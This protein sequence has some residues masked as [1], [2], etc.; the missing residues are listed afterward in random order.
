M[1]EVCIHGE[2][3]VLLGLLDVGLLVLTDALLK[4]VRLTCQG[5][6]V[7]PLEW[8]FHVVVL[9]HPEG[10]EKAIGHKLD[11]LAHETRVHAD[12]FDGEGLTDELELDGHS[13]IHDGQ[14]ALVGD[15]IRQVLVQEAR[16]VCVHALI[17]GDELVGEGESG[18]ESA[19]LEPEDGAEGATEEDA[20]DCCKGH[21]SLSEGVVGAYPPEGPVGLLADHR[22]VVDRLQQEVLLCR[23]GN[24]GVY[25]K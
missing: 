18:H 3:A 19:L 5:D 7:H 10:E 13:A 23:V 1:S 16:E 25:Q 2:C 15:L 6:H 24:V 17:S 8:V 9:G 20:F 4:E 22:D 11:V 12:E 21:E 14:D